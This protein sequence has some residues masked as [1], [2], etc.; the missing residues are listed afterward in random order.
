[1]PYYQQ[2]LKAAFDYSPA[3]QIVAVDM[4]FCTMSDLTDA[5]PFRA[6]AKSSSA[7]Q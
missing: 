6:L 7:T 4:A 3:H 5:D 1:M 2:S